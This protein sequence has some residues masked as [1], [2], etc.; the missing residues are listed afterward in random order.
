M[1][2]RPRILLIEDEARLAASLSRG[3]EEEGYEVVHAADGEEGETLARS[4]PFTIA[5]VDWRL[6]LRDGRTVV[7]NLRAAGI[8]TP[9]IMLTALG[10]IDHR[11]AGLDAGAD[12]YL[13]KPFAFEELLARLRALARRAP[14]TDTERLHFGELALDLEHRSLSI[15]NDDVSLRTKEFDLLATLMKRPRSVH[16][17]SDLAEAVWGDSTTSDNTIDVTVSN[18]RGKLA[19]S[20]VAVEA[21]RGI[22]YRLVEVQ[23]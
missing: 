11:I 9:V 2:A 8:E 13:A 15:S 18:L 16:S 5:V 7:S 3:L 10:D 1:S 6:P 20:G 14:Q 17:R 23:P 22:G 19:G 12:D 21:V 4:Q